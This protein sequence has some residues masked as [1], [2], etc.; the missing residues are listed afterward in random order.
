MLRGDLEAHHVKNFSSNEDKR[1]DIDNGLTM[2]R[3]C[4]NP[5]EYNSFHHIYGTRNNTKEQLEEYIKRYKNDE[6]KEVS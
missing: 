4:H 6:F 1:F 3:K 2:C 5:V